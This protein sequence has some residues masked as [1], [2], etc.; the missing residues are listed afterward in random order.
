M[1]FKKHRSIPLR[2][3][4]KSGESGFSIIELSILLAIA[5][6]V[7]ANALIVGT[8][9]KDLDRISDSLGKLQVIKDSLT[10]YVKT[11]GHYP[12]PAGG[13]IA[14]SSESVGIGICSFT[15]N[16]DTVNGLYRAPDGTNSLKDV[17]I[18]VVPVKD[19]RL[20]TSFMVDQWGNRI[21]Y[22]VVSAFTSAATYAALTEGSI[23]INS[24]QGAL[25]S[26]VAYVLVS[27][28]ENGIGAWNF[29]GTQRNKPPVDGVYDAGEEE[30]HHLKTGD[31]WDSVFYFLTRPPEDPSGHK[32]L[33]DD[34]L[35][36]ST[37]ENIYTNPSSGPEQ[38]PGLILWY[39]ATDVPTFIR[40]ASEHVLTWKDKT[41]VYNNSSPNDALGTAIVN[42][43][44]FIAAGGGSNAFV[45]PPDSVFSLNSVRFGQGENDGLLVTHDATIDT[46]SLTAFVVA[47]SNSDG[48]PPRKMFM[49]RGQSFAD[50]GVHNGWGFGSISDNLTRGL[51]L[52]NHTDP[53]KYVATTADATYYSTPH[54]YVGEYDNGYFYF[55][56]L[57]YFQSCTLG[58]QQVSNVTSLVPTDGASIAIGAQ[59]FDVSQNGINSLEGDIGEV[60]VYGVPLTDYD[61][62]RIVKYLG[63]K[64][65]ISTSDCTTTPPSCL[66]GK[67]ALGS[68]C[69]VNSDC[70]SGGC[71]GTT[72]CMPSGYTGGWERCSA[73]AQCCGGT[74]SMFG[75]CWN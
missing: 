28:G 26:K 16:E 37:V 69:S 33:F 22:A 74:C 51:W 5:A 34:V 35:M 17:L 13:K 39:D 23:V 31:P 53:S 3:S 20:P 60:V 24:P 6:F 15:G 55:G 75:F 66:P 57:Q 14:P 59:N 12:C 67:A 9:R 27:H 70:C 36:W 68:S 58:A 1:G 7:F 71:N 32:M 73:D 4:F 30:N 2:H 43:P 61:R 50:A 10:R 63:Q 11:Q 65:G 44:T 46:N 62:E 40:D 54:I 38:I 72:C 45:P 49:G 25:G 47:Y 42:Y 8:A 29:G 19:L 48:L 41:R 64:W 21:T 18:G 52:D 56:L